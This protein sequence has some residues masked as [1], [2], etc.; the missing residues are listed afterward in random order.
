MKMENPSDWV[1]SQEGKK[2]KAEQDEDEKL[3]ISCLLANKYILRRI[4][5]ESVRDQFNK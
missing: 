4:H 1:S 2:Q 3:S 5:P